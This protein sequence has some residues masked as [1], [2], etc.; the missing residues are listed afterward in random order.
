MTTRKP[1]AK[2]GEPA[3]ATGILK[4]KVTLLGVRPPIWRRLLVAETMTLGGLHDVIQEAMGW[5]RCHLHIFEINGER[6]SDPEAFPEAKCQDRYCLSRLTKDGVKKFVYTYDFGDDWAHSIVVEGQQAASPGLFYPT[7]IAGKRA[8][9]PEDCGGIGGYGGL[10]EALTTPDHPDREEMLE[11]V[12]DDYDPEAF[13]AD[14]V[15]AGF[16]A[17]FTPTGKRRS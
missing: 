13:S 10:L 11:W 9:P 16:K 12:G 14:V 5:E 7:C 17:M 4:I 1:E 15:N 6:F 3:P 2:S 8:G